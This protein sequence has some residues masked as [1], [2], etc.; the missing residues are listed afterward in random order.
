MSSFTADTRIVRIGPHHRPPAAYSSHQRALLWPVWEYH[1][2]MSRGA[3]QR[4]ELNILQRPVLE[5]CL[6]GVRTSRSIADALKLDP[7]LV[8]HILGELLELGFVDGAGRP[9]PRLPQDDAI[10]HDDMYSVLQDALGGDIVPRILRRVTLVERR[11][12]STDGK[13]E[14]PEIRTGGRSSWTRPAWFRP[15]ASVHPA[16]PT[17]SQLLHAGSLHR[18]AH[19]QAERR[20]PDLDR[21]NPPPRVGRVAAVLDTPRPAFLLISLFFDQES[22][23]GAG[24]WAVWDPSLAAPSTTLRKMVADQLTEL[25]FLATITEELVRDSVGLLA[26]DFEQVMA[27]AR[28]DGARVLQLRIPAAEQIDDLAMRDRLVDAFTNMAEARLEP[29]REHT[30][31]GRAAVASGIFT[32]AV[33]QQAMATCGSIPPA[34]LDQLALGRRYSRELLNERAA[35]LG[36]PTPLP[37]KLTGLSEMHKKLKGGFLSQREKTYALLLGSIGDL[38]SPWYNVARSAPDVFSALEVIAES[39]NVGA[40][41]G[42]AASTAGGSES[43]IDALSQVVEL[44]LAFRQEVDI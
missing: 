28:S 41:V 40:H 34:V 42:E 17:V 26:Q 44:H 22:N 23:D 32:E 14:R 15:T 3:G 31:L 33:L 6:A 38:N 20:Y 25:P 5:M 18:R 16:T 10:G 27:H 8:A 35:S 2:A 1:I 19:T 13:G 21:P 37:S 7:E 39:R 36:F 29:S 4:G 9:G 12:T 30:H 11:V 24:D 43:L